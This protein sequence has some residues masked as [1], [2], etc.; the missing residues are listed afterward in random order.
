MAAK[1]NGAKYS[2][3][4]S[5]PTM[6][7]AKTA[8]TDARRGRPAAEQKL[9]KVHKA[10]GEFR[11]IR[12]NVTHRGSGA[13]ARSQQHNPKRVT[14]RVSARAGRSQKKNSQLPLPLPKPG[15]CPYCNARYADGSKVACP[16]GHK[17]K[18]KNGRR[19]RRPKKNAVLHRG[20]VKR[21]VLVRGRGRRNPDFEDSEAAAADM[22]ETFHGRPAE[23]VTEFE[24]PKNERLN[25]AECGKL[26]YL[27]VMSP[28]G[29][30]KLHPRGVLVCTSP[31]G[32]QL[33]FVG[34][35]QELDLEG[36]GLADALPK[37]LLDIGSCFEIEYHTTKDFHNFD[38]ID[39]F[40]NFGEESGVLPTLG[41]DNLNGMFYLSGGN[42]QVKR[43]GI[44]D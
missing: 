12:L 13:G 40:H 17:A 15:E 32:G 26:R 7:A 27:N 41:Y 25:L 42:Y 11:V 10:F 14:S 30:Y 6:A 1:R 43:E 3:V 34:G 20:K 24:V 35:D 8:L 31:E 39:Y 21:A 44:V 9:F 23:K 36:L 28:A 37:D 19:A 18:A 4:T 2:V 22:F 38:P 29:P 33:Y 5:R 16:Y